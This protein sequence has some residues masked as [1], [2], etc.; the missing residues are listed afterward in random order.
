MP[1]SDKDV[2]P[3]LPIRISRAERTLHKRS[4]TC[5]PDWLCTPITADSTV[6]LRTP[7]LSPSTSSSASTNTMRSP[8][9][10]TWKRTTF[11]KASDLT[12]LR[13]GSA[14]PSQVT[15][16][17]SGSVLS[18]ASADAFGKT[19]FFD[20]GDFDAYLSPRSPTY[21]GGASMASSPRRARSHTDNS[22]YSLP[23]SFN[24]QPSGFPAHSPKNSQS[25][26]NYTDDTIDSE[27]LMTSQMVE[28]AY[29]AVTGRPSSIVKIRRSF[30]DERV[31]YGKQPLW[32]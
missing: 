27:I 4:A 15:L 9:S 17:R 8:S 10:A 26:S 18:F 20:D 14:S 1:V 31:A 30:S 28:S 7:V 16:H 6:P 23:S 3:P 13:L 12:K 21:T 19:D 5:T 22:N 11:S 32:I 2:L 25:S 24:Y 29:Q